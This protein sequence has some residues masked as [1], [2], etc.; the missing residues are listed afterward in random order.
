[1]IKQTIL[2]EF[3]RRLYKKSIRKSLSGQ[4]KGHKKAPAR[5]GRFFEK[6]RVGF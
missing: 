2:F 6:I 5:S 1:M 4:R 3:Q